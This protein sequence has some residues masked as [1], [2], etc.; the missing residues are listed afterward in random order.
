ARG[1]RRDRDAPDEIGA[2]SS[3]LSAVHRQALR[4]AADQAA[5]RLDV[6]AL[7]VALSRRGQTLIQRQLRLIDQFE[8][9]ETDPRILHRLFQLDHLAA[10][11][12]R[13][14]ENLL[15]LAGGEPGRRV[16]RAVPLVDLIR[17]AAAE[18]EDY[19]RVDP[20]DV[21][22]VGVAAH[23]ARDMIH[24]L[25]ELMENATAFSP[26]SSR[27]RVTARRSVDVVTISV[28]DDGIGMPA[29]QVGQ[30]NQRLR[31]PTVLTAELAGT[32]GLL[33]VGRLA[34]RHH[35][36]V[37]LRSTQAG[38]TVALVGMP[39]AIL[40]PVPALTVHTASV[41]HP[42]PVAIEAPPQRPAPDP[43]P[44]PA[45]S[46]LP[47]RRPG[48]LLLPGSIPAPVPHGEPDARVD[49]A[50]TPDPEL[51]RAR[52]SGLGQ[53]LARGDRR[54][55]PAV[56]PMG[57]GSPD[58]VPLAA[59]GTPAEVNAIPE[60]GTGGTAGV[61]VPAQRNTSDKPPARARKAR[62]SAPGEG[63]PEPGSQASDQERED[64]A[65]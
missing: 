33:V 21:A 6:A 64:G 44:A 16:L 15:V 27:V 24:L 4:L 52:L 51:V 48:G 12:R 62:Q 17:A 63:T 55:A 43:L 39:A 50:T 59:A 53:G 57:A 9:S 65:R 58:A 56:P 37:E 20:V 42:D 60:P 40:A 29:D 61:R 54:P 36:S 45:G 2:V 10:R 38:G 5:L 13:N 7:F 19:D 18:I 30:L 3:A 23:A 8:R 35:I 32:M 46:P 34:A 28:F 47:R 1:S 49:G 25:A 11:M 31:H 26:P 14:E 22:E 41:L